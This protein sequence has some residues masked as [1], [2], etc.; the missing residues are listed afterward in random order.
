MSDDLTVYGPRPTEYTVSL[1]PHEHPEFRNFRLVI[2]WRG[3]D[4]WAITDGFHQCLSRS[5]EWG[6]EARPSEREDEWI[7]DNRFSLDEAIER[8]PQACIDSYA[9]S[10]AACLHKWPD[11]LTWEQR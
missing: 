5:G 7:A 10:Y 11:F 6:W 1:L 3:G 9:D 8:A 4:R 2:Q